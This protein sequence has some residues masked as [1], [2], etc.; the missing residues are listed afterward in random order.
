MNRV[1]KYAH[2]NIELPELPTVLL[3]TI[4]SEFLEIKGVNKDCDKF[5]ES[6]KKFPI[7]NC[8]V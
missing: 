5:E 4:Q 3:N 2:L 7:L 8:Y 6:C 1:D